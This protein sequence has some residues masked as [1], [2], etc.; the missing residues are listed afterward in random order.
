MTDT[1][2]PRPGSYPRCSTAAHLMGRFVIWLFGW[3]VAGGVPDTNKMIIVAAPHTSNWDLIFLL[4]AAFTFHL[5]IN[6]LGKDS[7][8]KT[9]FGWLM[10]WTGG[11]PVD[12][13]K[14]NNMVASLAEDIGQRDSCAIVIPPAGTRARTEFWKSGFYWVARGAEIPLVCGYLDYAKKEAGLGL[15]F[16]PTSD[17][18]RDMDR[19]R[20][21]YGEIVAKFPEKKSVIR[22]KDES[23]N[24]S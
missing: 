6:W 12:R 10:R 9:G 18:A 3:K 21:F 14:S 24:A 1:Q 4:G 13:S 17:V 8:F 19:L 16:M 22:L 7:L 23:G 11:I 20:D 15:C 5:R 2:D